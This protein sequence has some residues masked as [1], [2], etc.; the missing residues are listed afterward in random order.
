VLWKQGGGPENPN[1]YAFYTMDSAVLGL[2]SSSCDCCAF[3][4]QNITR[5]DAIGSP[6]CSA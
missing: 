1:V 3:C 5:K 4:N 6:L 2:G